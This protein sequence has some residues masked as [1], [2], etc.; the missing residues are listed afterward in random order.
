MWIRS[1]MLVFAVGCIGTADVADD[2][3]DSV[4]QNTGGGGFTCTNELSIQGVSCVG[5]ISVLALPINVV[6]RNVGFLDNNKLNVLRGDLNDV[7]ILDGGIVR[8]DKIL[9]DVEVTTL[10]DFL[11]KFLV[12]VTK[13]DIDVCT[14]IIDQPICK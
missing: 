11:D 7:S 5:S 13:N 12:N 2:Q 8:Y 1:M 4:E 6:I 9:N 3:T 10:N 14:V